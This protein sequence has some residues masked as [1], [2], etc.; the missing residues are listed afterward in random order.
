MTSNFRKTLIAVAVGALMATPVWAADDAQDT[1]AAAGTPG[2]MT[3][4]PGETA[5][6]VSGKEAETSGSTTRSLSSPAG[7]ALGTQQMDG[8]LYART[9]DDLKG[10]DV[11]DQSGDDIGNVDSVVLGPDRGQAHAIVTVGGLLGMGGRDVMVPLDQ[12]QLEGDDQLRI[13]STREQLEAL[14]EVSD[15]QED[16]YVELTGDLPLRQ[17]IQDFA[18]FEPGQQSGSAPGT[19]QP[20]MGQP[21]APGMGEGGGPSGGTPDTT[22]RTQEPAT[23][24]APQTPR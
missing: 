9:A 2:A 10:M 21:G 13:S 16:R 14:P 5:P 24:T 6:G 15:E 8:P 12:L 1:G 23:D 4:T 22:P 19:P 3:V 18:A 17:S 20:S 7:H 11:V